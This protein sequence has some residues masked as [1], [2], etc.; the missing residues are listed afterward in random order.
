[1]DGMSCITFITILFLT[2]SCNVVQAKAQA[3]DQAKVQ[4]K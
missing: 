4:A 1:M 2:L 3:G